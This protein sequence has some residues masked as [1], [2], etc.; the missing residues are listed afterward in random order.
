LE[1][2]E[3]PVAAVHT[4]ERICEALQ[5]P[6]LVHQHELFVTAS[7]G[8]ALT[9]AGADSAND[10]LRYADVAMYRAK[11]SGRAG[12]ALYDP[13][14]NAYAARRLSLETQLR[15]AVERGEFRVLYQPKVDLTNG[16]IV[17]MEALLR[18]EHPE[19]GLISPAEF[20]P[21]AE[22]TGL[23]LPIGRWVL[24]EACRQ[25]H[26]WQQQYPNAIGL[27]I[28]VNLSARQFQ[29]PG[30]IEEVADVL[31]MTGLEPGCLELEITES[32]VMHDAQLT[33][34]TLQQLKRLGVR[35]AIDDFGTGY[36]SL[37]YLKRF[38][39]DVLKV[40]K[41]FVDGLGLDP[42][43]TA[44]VQ[45]VTSLGHALRLHIVAEGVETV[46]QALA[47]RELGCEVGQGY[48]FSR[49]LPEYAMGNLL[50]AGAL[51]EVAALT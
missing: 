3:D 46:E 2:L 27:T 31:K 10:L 32:V 49:P 45:A 13:S 8:I 5:T 41:S 17:G 16:C 20:I 11:E 19:H 23:I 4:A 37:S 1:D 12:Y 42:D 33:I 7:V 15:R 35:L 25:T 48:H 14:M 40:D 9:V 51:L 44:I 18:W 26:V 50:A 43:D 28:S 24:E 30:L 21:L 38:P 6:F 47:L 29:Q 39:V 36:S 34:S 22:E